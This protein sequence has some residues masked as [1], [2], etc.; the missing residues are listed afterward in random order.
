MNT[1]AYTVS[2]N[3][4]TASPMVAKSAFAMAPGRTLQY[5][6]TVNGNLLTL[7]Q[8]PEGPVLKFIRL[9]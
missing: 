7:V 1:G 2:G 6:F 3:L 8:K 5:E 9:E 4:L